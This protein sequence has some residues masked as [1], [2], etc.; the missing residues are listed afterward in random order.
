MNLFERK[1][2]T[3]RDETLERF[4]DRVREDY[5]RRVFYLNVVRGLVHLM[6]AFV[7][8]T[9]DIDS[10]RFKQAL[11][12]LSERFTSDERVKAL[13]R[14]FEGHKDVILEFIG[15]QHAYIRDR[16]QELRDIID[17]LGQA[18][19]GLDSDNRTFQGRIH[20]QSEK[21]ERLTDLDDIKRIKESLRLEV[22]RIHEMLAEKQASDAAQM[23]RLNSQIEA[24]NRELSQARTASL[25]DGLTGA[26]NRKAFDAHLL[27]RVEADTVRP[28]PFALLLVDIDDFKRINDT[29][30][31]PVGD[32]VLAS[33]V[34]KCRHAVRESDFLARYGGEEFAVVLPGAGLRSAA[35]RGRQI[36]KAVAATR[37]ALSEDP[38]AERLTVTV[39]VGVGVLR[40]GDTVATL[41][42]RVDQA[43]YAAK[44]GGKNRVA[45][46]KDADA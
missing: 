1:P 41:T 30:G 31:H 17:L 38:G 46:E 40:R 13:A 16:E 22:G 20:A 6:K 10:E 23:A 5:E 15:R 7:V 37:Y 4:I 24:L 33:V 28:A 3:V 39:S 42:A 29:Y 27:Q 44:R 43:L 8:E 32:R 2:A 19:A 35:K 25:V 9:R 26:Y 21:I 14:F 36:C 45:T 11:D 18:M 12:R 34:D